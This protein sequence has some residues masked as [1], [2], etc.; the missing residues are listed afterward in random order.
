MLHVGATPV[1][2][3][4][5]LPKS[6][7]RGEGACAPGRRA[8]IIEPS[9]WIGDAA[10]ARTPRHLPEPPDR[11]ER[12]AQSPYQVLRLPDERLRFPSYGGHA[13]ARG[14]CR[15]RRARGC[16]P[17]H[18][19][20]LQYPR[21]GGREGLFRARPHPRAQA[22]GGAPGAPP[23]GR[24]GG[25]RRPGG[26]RGDHPP[27]AGGRSRGRTAELPSA[28]RS[29][30]ASR[31]RR[32]RGRHRI[33]ARGQV[34]ST[35]AAEPGGHARA[36]HLR[37]RH[38]AGRLRQVLHLLRRALYARRRAVAPGRQCGRGNR[39]AR[40]RG[41]A[42]S[43]AARPERQRLSRRRPGRAAVAARA[44]APS[45]RRGAGHCAAAL[46]DQPSAR[47]GAEPDRRAPRAAEPDALSASAGAVGI[48]PRARRHEPPAHARRL[49]RH[50][51]AHARRVSRHRVLLRL[52][53]RLP[54]RER[55]GFRGDAG[56]DRGGRLRRR[57]LVQV[58]AA[59]GNS[60]RRDG[61]AGSRR[62]EIGAA[63][64]PAGGDRP[65][66][67]RFQCALRRPHLRRPVRKTRTLSWPTGRPL[68]ISPAGSGHGRIKHDRGNC[69]SDD[70]RDQRQQPVRR[71]RAGVPRARPSRPRLAAVEG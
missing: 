64:S 12:I 8:G 14:L 15:D 9:Q 46:H 31:A 38:R 27:R 54:G 48:G 29:A 19:Q 55:G 62:G 60:G 20:H 22:G 28:A 21:E 18:P 57:L 39:A 16:R 26:R 30:R 66:P 35:G 41:R 52:H 13:R 43:H 17:G 68:P 63:L 24:G 49:S 36:W 10:G 6:A 33:S 47:H 3:F 4:L 2:P 5:L 42:R 44:L 50:H 11:H 53:R 7:K 56:A 23:G 34:R 69:R 65:A 45:R 67:G 40:R 51:C 71:A 58:L 70:H 32:S 61:R 25:L 37:L 1:P 59:A